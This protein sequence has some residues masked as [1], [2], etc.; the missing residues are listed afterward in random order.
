[1]YRSKQ[2]LAPKVFKAYLGLTLLFIG[3]KRFVDANPKWLALAVFMIPNLLFWSSGLLKEALLILNLG[4]L[5]YAVSKLYDKF[6]IKHF[7][8][9]LLGAGLFITT[10]IYVLICMIPAIIFLLCG[11]FLDPIYFSRN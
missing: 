3:I 4:I 5:F 6:T 10:K 9:F 11:N 2:S 8:L 7:L 1:M